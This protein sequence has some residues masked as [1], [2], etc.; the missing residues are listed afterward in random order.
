MKKIVWVAGLLLL[1]SVVFPNGPQLPNSGVVQ[2]SGPTDATIVKL[3]E[4]ATAAD[5][6]RIV[7][8]YTGLIRV[9]NKDLQKTTDRR[10][11][12]TEKWEE[13][14]Q[15]TLDIAVDE[16]GKYPGLDEAIEGVFTRTVGTDDVLPGNTETLQK[17]ITAC[18]TVV[19]SAAK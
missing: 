14:Q 6:A 18:E 8:T 12:T 15:N 10:I 5:K 13:L 19:N 17:L 11:S 16:V 2:P 7:G 1:L 4:K 3:L 9:L